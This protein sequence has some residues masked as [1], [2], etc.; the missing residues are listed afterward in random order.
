MHRLALLLTMLV[1]VA[2][3]SAQKPK[4]KPKPTTAPTLGTVQLP[5][6]NGKLKTTYQLGDKQSELH[7]NLDAVSVNTIFP[8]PDDLYVAGAKERLLVLNFTV[9]NPLNREQRLGSSSFQFT[10]VSPDDENFEFRGYLLHS[11]KKTHLDQS[12]KPA[13]KVK[14]TVVIPIYAAGP[15]SKLMVQRGS[16]KVLRYDLTNKV[17]KMDSVFSRDGIDLL[18]TGTPLKPMDPGAVMGPLAV[19]YDGILYTTEK[20]K[21]YAPGPGETYL[22][23]DVTFTNVMLKPVP[24]GFQYFSP[25]ITDTNGEKISWNRDLISRSMAAS[26]G[27]MIEPGES[28]SGRYYFKITAGRTVKTCRFTHEG[29]QRTVEFELPPR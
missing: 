14:C 1:A 13:Q 20:I 28:V 19:K 24:V 10:V 2:T 3:V 18:D 8:A 17:E 7:F 5:G 25:Q 11:T 15:V 26:I 12:L 6:D 21:G 27:Q 4:P 16:G 22:C 9:Q 23:I 29:S